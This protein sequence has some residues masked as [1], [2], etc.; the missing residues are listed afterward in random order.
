LK[1]T[2]APRWTREE[3]WSDGS[4][5]DRDTVETFTDGSVSPYEAIAKD[6]RGEIPMSG[7]FFGPHGCDPGTRELQL[8]FAGSDIAREYRQPLGVLSCSELARAVHAE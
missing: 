7:E 2:V 3:P 6:V 5:S 8:I 4:P 1:G